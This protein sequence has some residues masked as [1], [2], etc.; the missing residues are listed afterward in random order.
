MTYLISP[1]F[2]CFTLLRCYAWTSCPCKGDVDELV[3]AIGHQEAGPERRSIP[4][5][6]DDS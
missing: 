6:L 3:F 2:R 4:N 1:W 5:R